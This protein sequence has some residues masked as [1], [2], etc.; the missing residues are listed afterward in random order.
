MFHAMAATMGYDKRG[1]AAMAISAVDMALHDAAARARNVPV[2]ALL[3]GALRDSMFAYASGPFL[4]LGDDPYRDFPADTEK[5]QRLGY[6]AFKPRIGHDPRA[7]GRS[8]VAMRKQ[9]GPDACADGRHQP[10]FYRPRRHR[11][12]PA[13]GGGGSALDRGTGSA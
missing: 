2:S 8:I 13:H 10:G 12:C 5:L 4:K 9:I 11:V 3:G 1:A 6:R 7:D